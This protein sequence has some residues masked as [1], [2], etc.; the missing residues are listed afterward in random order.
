MI[1]TMPHTYEIEL[2]GKLDRAGLEY[3]IQTHT[4][5]LE[6]ETEDRHIHIW[7]VR[8]RRQNAEGYTYHVYTKRKDTIYTKHIFISSKEA[9]VYSQGII[10]AIL[11][12]T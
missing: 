7:Q 6:E 9:E 2:T 12:F 11:S 3:R 5:V 4:T 1:P 10:L 8:V